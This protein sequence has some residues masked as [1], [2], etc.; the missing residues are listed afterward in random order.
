MTELTFPIIKT[1][2]RTQSLTEKDYLSSE[3]LYN[4]VSRLNNG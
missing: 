4:V 2:F 1:A 3:E